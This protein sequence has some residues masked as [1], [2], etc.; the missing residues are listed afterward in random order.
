MLALLVA[1]SLPGGTAPARAELAVITIDHASVEDIL[2]AAQILLTPDGKLS[3]DRRT[4]ALVVVDS[5][6]AIAGIRALLEKLDRPVPQMIVRV[7][8]VEKSA[9]DE[10]SLAGQGRISV[11]GGS[12]GTPGPKGAGFNLTLENRNRAARHTTEQVLRTTSGRPALITVGR[13]IPY[14][15]TWALLCRKYAACATTTVFHRVETGFEV[16]PSVRGDR[17][18]LRITPRIGSMDPA[19]P[20]ATRFA[21]AATEISVAPGQWIDLGALVATGNEVFSEILGR[22]KGGRHGETNIMLMVEMIRPGS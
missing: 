12:V 20:G 1:V 4:H 13:E 10:R 16:T 15:Q 9:D 22:G 19:A 5:P 14:S 7:R 21:E 11:P 8:F 18:H 6:A 17:A 2:P 3:F